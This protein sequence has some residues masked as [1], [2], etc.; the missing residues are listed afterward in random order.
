MRVRRLGFGVEVLL[1]TCAEKP[2]VVDVPVLAIPTQDLARR[3]EEGHV[4]AEEVISEPQESDLS[5]HVAREAA[6]RVDEERHPDCLR[7][8]EPPEEKR[9]GGE[10]ACRGEAGKFFA[11]EEHPFSG[12]LERAV[13]RTH[14]GPAG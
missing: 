2:V 5:R 12:D 7:R 10:I 3:I 9:F 14:Q 6:H 1:E 11:L 8:D 4:L 13:V